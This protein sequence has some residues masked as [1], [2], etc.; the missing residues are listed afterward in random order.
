MNY[1]LYPLAYDFIQS[2]MNT[3]ESKE[4]QDIEENDVDAMDPLEFEHHCANVL[5]K[6]GW[7]AYATKGSGD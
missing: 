1:P 6:H 3:A 4:D 5:T 2:K 7:N